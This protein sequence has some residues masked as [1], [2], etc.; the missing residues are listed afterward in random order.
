MH[1]FPTL[2]RAVILLSRTVL[3]KSCFGLNPL[4]LLSGYGKLPE[5]SSDISSLTSHTLSIFW[6][7]SLDTSFSGISSFFAA[8]FLFFA[9]DIICLI[10]S[11]D[12]G[13]N[14]DNPSLSGPEES[15]F[16]KSD[17]LLPRERL[18]KLMV[19]SGMVP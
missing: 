1:Q 7:V 13:S 9:V 17:E 2:R 19:G 16:D 8:S 11:D 4:A 5:R 12:R 10:A 15:V 18:P 6:L 3:N 14:H